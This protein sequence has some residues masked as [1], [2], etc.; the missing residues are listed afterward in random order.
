[1]ANFNA[2]QEWGPLL[3]AMVTPMKEDGSVDYAEAERLADF[4]IDKQSNTGLVIAGTTGESPTL[5]DEEKL[6]LLKVTLSAVGKKA[7]ILFGAG[8]YDTEHSIHLT[9]EATK[10][11]AHG[12]M[13]VSPYYNKPNQD[14]LYAHFRKVAQSTELPV[15][16]YNIQGRTA[17]NLETKT[18]LR[19]IH[20]VPNIC[21]VKEASGN[22]AQVVEV[23]AGVPENFAVYSGDDILTLPILS[24]GGCG[25]V[26]VA[27]HVAGGPIRTMIETFFKGDVSSA[28]RQNKA[29]VPLFK[30]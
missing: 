6:E 18:L 2:G 17:V 8:T 20:D 30:A 27:A 23:C 22:L 10:L 14:G 29:L 24:A 7:K 25:V 9:K 11:G 15:M 21:A 26:S 19:L 4:L 28:A 13:L 5:S 16:L 12:I 3:T 1:M